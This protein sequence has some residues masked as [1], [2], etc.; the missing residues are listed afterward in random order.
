MKQMLLIL[1]TT[2]ISCK[3]IKIDNFYDGSYKILMV[4]GSDRDFRK[5]IHYSDEAVR[6]N[7]TLKFNKSINHFYILNG[8]QLISSF[9][10]NGSYNEVIHYAPIRKAQYSF[11]DTTEF[12]YNL[13]IQKTC[14]KRY[15]VTFVNAES[16]EDSW[17]EK[18]KLSKKVTLILEKIK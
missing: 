18:N 7:L 17:V 15:K 14:K 5:I 8:E 1:C 4:K 3:S 10:K 13:F 2:L 6:E 12:K 16:Y 9:E 11:I